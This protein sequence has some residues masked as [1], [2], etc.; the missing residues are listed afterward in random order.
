[1]K[2]Y[3]F[4]IRWAIALILLNYLVMEAAAT[5]LTEDK[6]DL[7]FTIGRGLVCIYAGWLVISNS[8]G[9]LWKASL[10]G[11]LLLF[12]DHVFLKGG[13]YLW[14]YF[15]SPA[16]FPFDGLMAFGGV[17]ISYFVFVWVPMALACLGGI[18]ARTY[19]KHSGRSHDPGATPDSA[20]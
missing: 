13:T 16:T 3:F 18:A 19:F 9:G 12:I 8:V 1:M 4:E 6:I 20:L 14:A 17:V 7:L 5:W 2:N 10:T 11:A 15:F